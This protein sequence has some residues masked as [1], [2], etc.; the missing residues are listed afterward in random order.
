MGDIAR[1]LMGW[2][3]R[4]KELHIIFI[5]PL[6]PPCPANVYVCKQE[7]NHVSK[8]HTLNNSPVRALMISIFAVCP[9]THSRGAPLSKSFVHAHAK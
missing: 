6:T 9:A 3:D 1:S 8:Q 4:Q 2:S 5:Q 7:I